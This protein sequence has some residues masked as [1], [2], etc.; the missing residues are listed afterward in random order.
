MPRNFYSDVK[1]GTKKHRALV[2]MM[3][4][5]LTGCEAVRLGVITG[6]QGLSVLISALENY[7]G[8]DIRTF[9]VDNPD[10]FPG[11]Y[12]RTMH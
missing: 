9:P 6:G 11:S 3:L 1:P 4:H 10:R 5:G 2:Y 12:L 7:H 8:Y